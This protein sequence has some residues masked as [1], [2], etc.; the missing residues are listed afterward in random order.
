MLNQKKLGSFHKD[1][2]KYKTKGNLFFLQTNL[3]V[4]LQDIFLTHFPT[5]F[6]SCSNGQLS[7]K[8]WTRKQHH[9]VTLWTRS[10]LVSEFTRLTCQRQLIKKVQNLT[11]CPL[12]HFWFLTP[13]IISQD[14]PKKGSASCPIIPEF[15]YFLYELFTEIN[16]PFHFLG[17]SR[18]K[19]GAENWEKKL[20]QWMSCNAASL[21]VFGLG[22]R[23]SRAVHYWHNKLL[24]TV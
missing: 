10:S 21:G 6:A 1:S 19:R 4:S 12:A 17:F 15:L 5:A 16:F 2:H 11:V 14:Q 20:V 23:G 3:K 8:N 22:F 18:P 13:I 7:I 24:I 9:L